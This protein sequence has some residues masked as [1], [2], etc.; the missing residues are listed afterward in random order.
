MSLRQHIGC[1][2]DGHDRKS[3]GVELEIAGIAGER[4]RQIGV[5][6]GNG[7]LHVACRAVDIA[8]DAE[9]KLDVRG[10]DAAGGG[11]I[12]HIRN[13]AQMPFQRR[14]NGGRHDFRAGARKARG[15]EYGGY[16]DA[17][18]RS[19]RQERE[20]SDATQRHSERQQGG[21]YRPLDEGRGNIHAGPSTN[22]AS[23]SEVCKRPRQRAA[24]RSNAR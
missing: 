11:H 13:R 20:R 9:G 16:V 5:R 19:D 22:G 24:M 15:N 23:G 1:H 7:R 18:Q 21:R 3:G 12:I 14:G 4:C 6:G 17:R 8:V 10:A 2:G